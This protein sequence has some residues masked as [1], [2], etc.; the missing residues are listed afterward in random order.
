M[1]FSSSLT[2]LLIGAALMPTIMFIGRGTLVATHQNHAPI[3]PHER[4]GQYV[5]AS[6]WSG[7]ALTAAPGSVTS[8]SGS[9][10]VPA[11]NCNSTPNSAA[12]FWV[13][14]DGYSNNTVEQIGTDSDC[15]NGVASYYA[16]YEFYP[17]NSVNINSFPVSIGDVISAQITFD[18]NTKSFTVTLTDS[19]R[20]QQQP[21]SITTKMP[22]AGAASAEW[23]AEAPWS[24]GTVN[25]SN[26]GS[27][28]F[29]NCR[30]TVNGKATGVGPFS[31][32]NVYAITSVS[33][34]G[35][36]MAVPSAIA[37]DNADF[38]ITWN[39]PGP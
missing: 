36:P 14:I 18:A 23:I 3:G 10:K 8:T 17:H 35:T 5:T 24:G 1:K 15:N 29:M 33:K 6:G 26:F 32:S 11:V 4:N 38:S 37:P 27:I 34:N 39:S 13:G 7:Y 22:S 2:H 25:L 20:P 9:W 12:S 28:P 31:N 21:F 30:A 19:S 16:W